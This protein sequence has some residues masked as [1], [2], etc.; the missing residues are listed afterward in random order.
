M[1]NSNANY[2][3]EM[4]RNS[5]LFEEKM[6]KF[7]KYQKSSIYNDLDDDYND[8]E[9]DLDKNKF[10]SKRPL[11]LGDKE[12]SEE[13]D[14]NYQNLKIKDSNPKKPISDEKYDY[15]KDE[16]EA[17]D[18]DYDD[19]D[20][21]NK[22]NKSNK[23]YN[24]NASQKRKSF[25]ENNIKPKNEDFE[26]EEYDNKN[27]NKGGEKLIEEMRADIIEKS[28]IIKKLGNDLKEKQNLPTQS[29][30]NM[31]HYDHEKIS[32]ELEEKTLLIKNQ[33]E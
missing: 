7:K 10:K 24:Y 14:Y 29:E 2:I 30:F 32:N 27:K 4:E 13:D 8:D 33:E 1:D 25:N 26:D 19:Y 3:K 9:K 16:E 11:N 20:Y 5:K 6:N 18:I 21:G 22:K 23:N 17:N 15:Y 12:N 28:N 31:L